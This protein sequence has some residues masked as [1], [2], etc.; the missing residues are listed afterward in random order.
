MTWPSFP[1]PWNRLNLTPQHKDTICEL[2]GVDAGSE[3]FRN[4]EL[5]LL[6]YMQEVIQEQEAAR[7]LPREDREKLKPVAEVAAELAQEIGSFHP[8]AWSSLKARFSSGDLDA[9]Y[10]ILDREPYDDTEVDE[11]SDAGLEFWDISAILRRLAGASPEGA[12]RKLA[13]DLAA[14]VDSLD[15]SAYFRLSDSFN[16]S[17]VKEE[18]PLAECEMTMEIL[19]DDMATIVKRIARAT[20]I[21]VPPGP[22]CNKPMRGL[23]YRL[24]MIWE[25]NK[26][27]PP[28]RSWDWDRRKEIGPFRRLLEVCLKAVPPEC[29]PSGF[30]DGLIKEHCQRRKQRHRRSGAAPPSVVE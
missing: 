4:L 8:E 23:I 24:G 13:A 2:L 19:I 6:F 17:E 15:R 9:D 20:E 1:V 10:P 7:P 21:D 18:F 26:G 27:E 30:P 5:M 29:R 12:C 28:R 3:A 14:V 11:T 22:P 25:G 16:S